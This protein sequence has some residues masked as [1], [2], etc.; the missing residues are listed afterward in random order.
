LFTWPIFRGSDFSLW[1]NDPE[2]IGMYFLEP[3]Y[4]FFGLT[5]LKTKSGMVHYADYHDVPGKKLWNWGREPKDGNRKWE[6]GSESGDEPHM[7]G[8]GYGEV[9]S[10][11]MVNQDHLEWLMPEECVMWQEAWSP[12]NGLTNVNEVTEDAAFQLVP[13]ESKLLVYSF[14]MAPDLKLRFVS[15]GKQISEMKLNIKTSQLQEIDLKNIMGANPGDVQIMIEKGGERSGT[16]STLSR[17]E[18]KKASE[19]R[20]IPIF[21]EHSSESLATVAEFDHKLLFR[22]QAM[23]RYKEALE[24]DSLN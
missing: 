17:C 11:R 22:P 4:N 9:Q 7:H 13:E 12:I 5:N 10:G 6:H 3:R 24:L 18:Q 15:G 23:D 19:L 8:Y 16:I 2:V 1:I 20:E 14:T 21:K